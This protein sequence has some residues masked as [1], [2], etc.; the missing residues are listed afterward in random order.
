[1]REAIYLLKERKHGSPARSP[2]HNAR[3]VLEDALR[4]QQPAPPGSGVTVQEAAR[5]LLDRMGDDWGKAVNAMTPILRADLKETAWNS[6]SE[7]RDALFAALSALE[8]K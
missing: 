6:V 3:L 1:M 8:G 4:A 2:G 5:V 7:M